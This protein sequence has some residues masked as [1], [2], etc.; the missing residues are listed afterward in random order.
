MTRE[1]YVELFQSRGGELVA[2]AFDPDSGA[3]MFICV[4]STEAGPACGGIRLRQ[5]GSPVD[6]LE[7]GMRLSAAIH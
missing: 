6:A 5:Y 4:H 1:R 2:S 7:D 3:F